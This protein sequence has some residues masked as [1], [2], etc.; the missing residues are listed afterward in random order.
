M[1]KNTHKEDS[2]SP[3]QRAR[4]LNKS[5]TLFLAYIPPYDWRQVRDF[6]AK[7][8]I[9]GNEWVHENSL[10]KILLV[11][12]GHGNI[13]PQL[14]VNIEHIAKKNGFELHF[15]A[16][17]FK[18]TPQI[19]ST[20]RRMLD[21]DANPQV[22][23]QALSNTGLPS[24]KIVKGLRIPGV[25]SEFEAGCRAILGQQVSVAAAVNK[26]NHL[27]AY[28]AQKRHDK[29]A[30]VHNQHSPNSC[31]EQVGAHPIA[32]V[33]QSHFP[34]PSEVAGD[35]LMFLKIPGARRQT[36]IA[37][38]KFYDHVDNTVQANTNKCA[39]HVS[40]DQSTKNVINSATVTTPMLID[41][42]GIGPW[43]VNYVAMRAVGLSDI[44]LATDLVIKQQLSKFAQA[45]YAIQPALA[46]PWRS[47]LT[48]NLWS[49]ASVKDTPNI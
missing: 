14:E 32:A 20:V 13:R 2:C 47:Y 6:F 33:L 24:H 30:T 26:V 1:H 39:V 25:A 10:G 31:V 38:A 42:K 15:N 34:L 35:D 48:L 40:C 5:I 44:W 37:L 23:A 36:L 4:D 43:T 8:L 49:L 28:F 46:T 18:Y 7:R 11:N 17:Y 29:A 9:H 41:I 3:H 22:I 45:G 19:V 16:Q 21:I 27:H 12:A